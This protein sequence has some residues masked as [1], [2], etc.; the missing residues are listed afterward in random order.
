MTVHDSNEWVCLPIRG[1]D[2]ACSQ[3]TL[4]N[5][6]TGGAVAQPY[7]NSHWLSR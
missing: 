6:V 4:G 2:V 1:G 3:I 5:L 7:V